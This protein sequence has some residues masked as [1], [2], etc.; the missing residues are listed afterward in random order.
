[1]HYPCKKG[2]KIPSVHFQISYIHAF[3]W[4]MCS[5]LLCKVHISRVADIQFF[6]VLIY[7][8][9]R[10][11]FPAFFDPEFIWG[12]RIKY[13]MQPWMFWS[14][15]CI[16]VLFSL[17]CNTRTHNALT[18]TLRE[19]EQSSANVPHATKWNKEHCR[20]RGRKKH[21]A[22]CYLKKWIQFMYR[23]LFSYI[24]RQLT[25]YYPVLCWL[26]CTNLLI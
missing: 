23:F 21:W 13:E 6:S 22:R 20:C 7:A 1:M 18:I 10:V 12:R 19:Q 2:R 26:F 15:A 5:C 8:L 16:P 24:R 9:G 4:I 17:Q 25:L 3:L 11:A 14:Y